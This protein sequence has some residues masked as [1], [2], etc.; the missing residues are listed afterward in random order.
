MIPPECLE[1]PGRAFMSGKDDDALFEEPF[2][3]MLAETPK[4]K[5][6]DGLVTSVK[7]FGD[8]PALI[9]DYFS[10]LSDDFLF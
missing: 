9:V 6:D 2:Y 5:A 7:Q 3:E 10:G 8:S 4:C 1:R